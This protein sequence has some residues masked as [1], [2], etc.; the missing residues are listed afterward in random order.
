[1]TE[2]E[3]LYRVKTINVFIIII[4]LN[5]LKQNIC[6]MYMKVTA[7]DVNFN[8]GIFIFINTR[9]CV[10]GTQRKQEMFYAILT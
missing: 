5:E 7:C 9:K 8:S 10:V 6:E 3:T 1:M 2:P 4:K